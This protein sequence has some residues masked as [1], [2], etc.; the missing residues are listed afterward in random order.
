MTPQI[1]DMQNLELMK[2]QIAATLASAIVIAAGRPHSI[3][4]AIDI[5]R[6]VQFALYPAP[7]YGTYQ[8]WA[9]TKEA[10]LREIRK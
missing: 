7:S 2:A 9:K 5:A 3:Q 6:D 10:R 8:E 4:E 1:S